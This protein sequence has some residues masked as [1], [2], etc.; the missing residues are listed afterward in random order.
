MTD[1]VNTNATHE[2]RERTEAPRKP[3]KVNNRYVVTFSQADYDA[4]RAF[5]EGTKAVRITEVVEI[6]RRRMHYG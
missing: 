4:L 1:T 3:R 2:A 6:L 5:I